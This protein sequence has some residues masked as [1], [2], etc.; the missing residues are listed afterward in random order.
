VGSP[1]K[2]R[3][4]LTPPSI[5]DLDPEESPKQKEGMFKALTKSLKRN[6]GDR[7]PEEAST[8]QTRR[9]FNLVGVVVPPPPIPHSSYVQ[10]GSLSSAPPSV[11]NEPLRDPTPPVSSSP[12]LASF[13]S[14]GSDSVPRYEVNRLRLLLTASQ[15]DVRVQ[16]QEFEDRERRANE[17]FEAERQVY[18]EQIRAMTAWNRGEGSSNARRG[19]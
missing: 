18:E 1:K 16:R 12:S 6:K 10:L 8:S 17:R 5:D 19:H 7:S 4:D 2:E 11:V 15:E 3:R 13:D 9:R 14:A